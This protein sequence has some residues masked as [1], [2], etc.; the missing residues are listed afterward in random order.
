[1]RFGFLAAAAIAVASCPTVAAAQ[2]ASGVTIDQLAA[3]L[4]AQGLEVK[5]DTNNDGEVFFTTQMTATDGAQ[6]G[7]VIAPREC[8]GS[9]PRCSIVTLY[10]NFSWDGEPDAATLAKLINYND[11]HFRGRAY[12]FGKSIGV[13]HQVLLGDGAGASYLAARIAEFP[14]ILADFVVQ[15]RN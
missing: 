10:A 11:R 14:Q 9:T 6:Y 3:T 15:M 13:D 8:T 7:V 12:A 5:L 2:A 1:M 4:E